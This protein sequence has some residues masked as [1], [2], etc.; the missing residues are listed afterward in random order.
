V[1]THYIAMS[2]E[3]GCLPDNLEIHSSLRD[4][5]DSMT[6]MFELSRR[7][8]QELRRTGYLELTPKDGAAYVSINECDCQDPDHDPNADQ[9]QDW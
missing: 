8:A 1:Q 2:G 9:S 5:V 3:H 6:A 4:A 7:K